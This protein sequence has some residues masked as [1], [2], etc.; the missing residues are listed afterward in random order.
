MVVLHNMI[1]YTLCAHN[2]PS[3][4]IRSVYEGAILS[5]LTATCYVVLYI[6]VLRL[7]KMFADV[8]SFIVVIS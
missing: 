1:V 5:H 7:L 2:L 3:L 6:L 4:W 8:T